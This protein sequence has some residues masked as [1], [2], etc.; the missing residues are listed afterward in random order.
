MGDRGGR[1]LVDQYLNEKN[2]QNYFEKNARQFDGTKLAVSQILLKVETDNAGNLKTAME[3][4]Q[5]IHAEIKNGKSGLSFAEA[6]KKHSQ[7]PSATEGGKIGEIGFDGP[8]PKSFNDKVM[9]LKSG[10]ISKPFVTS[11]GVH[12]VR[13]DEVIAGG[14]RWKECETELRA[15]MKKYLFKWLAEQELKQTKVEYA[16]ISHFQEGTDKLER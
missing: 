11:F 5:K 14:K 4:A 13:C 10:E 1:N 9:N 15:A 6:A 7:S 3:K 16:D 2:L 12:L 8:M